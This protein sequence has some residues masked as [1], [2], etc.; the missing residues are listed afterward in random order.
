METTPSKAPP[1]APFVNRGQRDIAVQEYCDWQKSQVCNQT[2]QAEFQ[3][4]SDVALTH[5]FDLE[6]IYED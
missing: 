1:I 6:Q 2:L 4:A 5:G 3:K